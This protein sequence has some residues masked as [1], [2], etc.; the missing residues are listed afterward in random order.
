MGYK[1][2]YEEYIGQTVPLDFHVHHMDG[3]HENNDINN[4]IA[5]PKELHEFL[6]SIRYIISFPI[7]KELGE[8]REKLIKQELEYWKIFKDC[9]H[10]LFEDS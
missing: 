10:R 7:Y 3:N 4:L 1:K 9:Q 6:H 8:A 2:I 5:I